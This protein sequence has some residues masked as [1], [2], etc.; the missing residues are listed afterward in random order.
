MM[1]EKSKVG[2]HC[3]QQF[4]LL[5]NI[6]TRQ[7]SSKYSSKT[8][9]KNGAKLL[10]LMQKIGVYSEMT[11][12][13]VNITC[14]SVIH[15]NIATSSCELQATTSDVEEDGDILSYQHQ[16]ARRSRE[17][18]CRYCLPYQRLLISLNR[19]MNRRPSL[20]ILLG[21]TS[22]EKNLLTCFVSIPY[23]LDMG[24]FSI[25]S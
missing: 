12:F 22:N 5:V 24:Q 7:N 16:V 9:Y 15:H 4:S 2:Q 3:W 25:F 8:A 19:S 23:P 6:I 21:G 13:C 11:K 10:K 17:M 1:C 14:E 18:F 20:Q